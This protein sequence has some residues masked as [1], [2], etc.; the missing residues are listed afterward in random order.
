MTI[1]VILLPVS[2]WN[3]MPLKEKQHGRTLHL[4]RGQEARITDKTVKIKDH[5]KRSGQFGADAVGV[6]GL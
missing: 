1:C 6:G 5:L 2:W 3:K 4:V